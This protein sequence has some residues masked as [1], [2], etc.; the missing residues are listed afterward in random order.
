MNNYAAQLETIQLVQVEKNK[1]AIRCND[2]IYFVSSLMYDLFISLKNG[3]DLTTTHKNITSKYSNA[4]EEEQLKKIVEDNI[5]R[6]LTVK[7]PEQ[8]KA[9]SYISFQTKLF[10]QSI[11]SSISKVLSLLFNRYLFIVLFL[12]SSYVTILLLKTVINNGTL[13][14]SSI[15]WQDG[16]GLVLLS[17]FFLICI[18]IFHEIGHAAATY[19][20][21]IKAK[22]VGFGFYLFFPVLFTNVSEI[23]LLGRY[24]RI[25]VNIGGIY[26][27]LI[28]NVILYAMYLCEVPLNIISSLFVSN[29]ILIIYSFN[30]FMRND[31]YWIYSDLFD[32]PN[33]SATAF[34]YPLRFIHYLKGRVKPFHPSHIKTVTQQIALFIYAGSMY[35]LILMLPLGFLQL[36]LRNIDLTQTFIL[37][38]NQLNGVLY[39]EALFKLTKSMIFYSLVF[40]FTFRMFKMIFKKYKTI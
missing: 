17:Y 2:K 38:H 3:F 7:S 5:A 26:F 23:W 27:Q 24:K 40:Y 32:I 12:G 8:K 30:P 9:N 34:D 33:L 4:P 22:E 28:I 29:S 15:T 35:F 6:F 10:N 1:F 20:Y 18:A 21:G 31:G 11:L 13:F 39:Y 16:L 19:K 37:T 36:T 25:L 14:N